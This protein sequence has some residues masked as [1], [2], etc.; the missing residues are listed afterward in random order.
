MAKILLVLWLTALVQGY[1]ISALTG[2]AI[3][4]NLVLVILTLYSLKAPVRSAITAALWAGF[5]LD[6]ASYTH[7]GFRAVWFVALVGLITLVKR[8][9]LETDKLWLGILLVAAV[10]LLYNLSLLL[11]VAVSSSGF[12][13]PWQYGG[14]WIAEVIINCFFAWW[15][16]PKVQ[17]VVGRIKAGL[18]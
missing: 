8:A 17:W 6:I 10:S 15:F 9:G 13:A 4:P 14:R 3:V 16:A 1:F 18:V 11:M 2:A 7:F 5:W 12:L